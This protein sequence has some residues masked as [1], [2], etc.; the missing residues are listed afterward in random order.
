MQDDPRIIARQSGPAGGLVVLAQ[1]QE[2]LWND[3]TA[4]H[5]HTI[6]AHGECLPNLRAVAAAGNRRLLLVDLPRL[7]PALAA[8]LRGTAPQLAAGLLFN[9]LRAAYRSASQFMADAERRASG[10]WWQMQ[11]STQSPP[12]CIGY[13]WQTSARAINP[14]LLATTQ[15]AVLQAGG[16]GHY[17]DARG[18]A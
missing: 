7:A 2:I 18:A 9:Q 17:F 13:V 4:V 5:L 1:R 6:H 3:G 14:E 16:L 11:D 12:Q 8:T 15:A 10:C